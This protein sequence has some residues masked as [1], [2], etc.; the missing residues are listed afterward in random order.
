[1]NSQIIVN[2]VNFQV[3]FWCGIYTAV[4]EDKLQQFSD[5]CSLANISVF[6]MAYNNFGY[7]IHGK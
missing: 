5:V 6:A 2:F 7:Y 1:M 3:V 4:I